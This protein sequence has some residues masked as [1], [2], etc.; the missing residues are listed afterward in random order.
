MM[1]EIIEG[2][3]VPRE[4]Y[5]VGFAD[6]KGL[7]PYKFKAYPYG[8]SIGQRLDDKIIDA[9]QEG[10][11]LAYLDH[12]N[13]INE[14]LSSVSSKIKASLNKQGIKSAIIKPTISTGSKAYEKYLE[15]LTTEV[16]HKMVATR[17]GLGWIG[18]TDLFISPKFGPRL[19][20]V[21][22]LVDKKISANG[23]PI[24]KSKCGK[25]RICVEKCPADAAT[26]R[27][28]N[29][30]VYRD[31]FFNAYKCREKCGELARSKLNVDKRI[32]GI[33]VSVCPVGRTRTQKL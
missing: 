23:I 26:G 16:S 31:E 14:V 12:Y 10:P 7:L 21:S 19:R 29:F 24:N 27:L 30:N 8:I 32:C 1:K 2:N 9:I 13:R 18:K 25:C 20:L 15:T 17:A 4:N 33:C 11:T 22:I 5:I 28:W 3:L 6:L